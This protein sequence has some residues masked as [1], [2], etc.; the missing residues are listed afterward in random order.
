MES[1]GAKSTAPANEPLRELLLMILG[2]H[3]AAVVAALIIALNGFL[4][5]TVVA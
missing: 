5:W 4:I 3:A 1:Q 2:Q